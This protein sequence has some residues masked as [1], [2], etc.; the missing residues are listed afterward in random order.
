MSHRYPTRYQS[1]IAQNL[2]MHNEDTMSVE[3]VRQESTHDYQQQQKSLFFSLIPHEMQKAVETILIDHD[4]EKIVLMDVEKKEAE[5]T[6]TMICD[7]TSEHGKTKF[8]TYHYPI[9]Y[10]LHT[11]MELFIYMKHNHELVR[12]FH[13]LATIFHNYY[14][15]FAILHS[16]LWNKCIDPSINAYKD[17]YLPYCTLLSTIKDMIHTAEMIFINE[18]LLKYY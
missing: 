11:N 16:T 17:I 7:M 2:P 12:R 15:H 5:Q 8:M 9:I 4:D 1:K 10:R 3:E 6:Y 14:G 18:G 13:Y